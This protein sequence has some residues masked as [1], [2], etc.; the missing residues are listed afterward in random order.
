MT[1]P[2][3]KTESLIRE[4]PDPEGARHFY[5]RVTAGDARAARA[6]GRDE[7]LLSDALALAAW[8]PLLATTLEQNP[9]YLGWLARERADARVRTTEE[10]RESLA[11]FALTHTQGGA[12][13]QL[14]RFRRRELLRVYLRDIRRA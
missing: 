7:G 9:D 12:Q 5:E 3:A 13:V 1:K 8:S 4:L 14:A 10:L 6:F 11:R 2:D